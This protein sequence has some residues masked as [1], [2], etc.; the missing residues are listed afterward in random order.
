V[1]TS[2]AISPG[3]KTCV[4]LRF[5]FCSFVSIR[6]FTFGSSQDRNEKMLLTNSLA[7]LQAWRIREILTIF[8]RSFEEV[9]EPLYR[10]GRAG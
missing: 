1:P 7:C 6:G 10:V 5:L 8:Q 2:S 3:S 9:L 4:N